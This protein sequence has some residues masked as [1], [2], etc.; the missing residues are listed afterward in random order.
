MCEVGFS[1]EDEACDGTDHVG[2]DIKTRTGNVQ[3]LLPPREY[4]YIPG[5][6]IYIYLPTIDFE[7]TYESSPMNHLLGVT[8]ASN[9]E[10][11][12]I[13]SGSIFGIHRELL[14]GNG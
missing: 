6:Y 1:I 8:W 2:I 13:H 4:I 11:R 9:E 14:S 7:N 5:I 10:Q 12:N 3:R